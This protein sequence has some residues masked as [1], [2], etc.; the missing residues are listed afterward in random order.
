MDKATRSLIELT[1]LA[2]KRQNN[3][4]TRSGAIASHRFL[5][6]AAT[7]LLYCEEGL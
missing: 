5:D 7:Q 2:A 1:G 3:N 6:F 4:G